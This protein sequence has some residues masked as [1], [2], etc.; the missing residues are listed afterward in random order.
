MKM[1]PKKSALKVSIK[2]GPKEKMNMKEA[3]MDDAPEDV[4]LGDTPEEEA[5]ESPEYEKYELEEAVRVLTQA[6]EI[7]HDAKL[8]KAIQPLLEKKSKA[9]KSLDDLRAVAKEKLGTDR[10][11]A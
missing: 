4:G 5:A 10:V 1:E 7:Q 11:E 9:V 2:F 6:A 3:P 8:M